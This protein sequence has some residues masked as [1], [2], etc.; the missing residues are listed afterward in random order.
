MFMFIFVKE[1]LTC[2]L[3]CNSTFYTK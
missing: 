3:A 1:A 2:R